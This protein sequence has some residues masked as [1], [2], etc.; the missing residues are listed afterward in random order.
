MPEAVEKRAIGVGDALCL[1]AMA[2]GAPVI[3]WRAWLERDDQ[4]RIA[5]ISAPTPKIVIIRLRL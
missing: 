2:V 3:G 4:V 5:A 1:A